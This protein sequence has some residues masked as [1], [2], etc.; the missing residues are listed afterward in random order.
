[1]KL[2]LNIDVDDLARATTAGAVL[3]Q[4]VRSSNWGKLALLADPFDHGF[5]F[6]EFMGQGYDE[7]TSSA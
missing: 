3:E 6:V 1:M 4:P 2:L 5:C 7:I